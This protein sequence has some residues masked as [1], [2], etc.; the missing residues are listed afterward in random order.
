VYKY[1]KTQKKKKLIPTLITLHSADRICTKID[2]FVTG[3]NIKNIIV[4]F[5]DNFIFWSHNCCN[6]NKSTRHNNRET[7]YQH[8]QHSK[9]SILVLTLK[10]SIR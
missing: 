4:N 9:Q 8:R 5:G 6:S 7:E 2:T 3:D 1:P 10:P